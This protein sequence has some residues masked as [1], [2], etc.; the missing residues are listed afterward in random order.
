MLLFG[1]VMAAGF[2]YGIITSQRHALVGTSGLQAVLFVVLGLY[3]GHFWT[4][5]GQTLAMQTWR[6]RL[7]LPDGQPVTRSRATARYLLS[8]LWF[9]PAL[10]FLQLGGYK[11]SSAVTLALGIG[12]VV[13]AGLSRLRR[14]RQFL[15]DALCGTRLVD[16]ATSTTLPE[17]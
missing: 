17:R 11:S 2:V 3:F 6:I 10:L 15:H 5:R 16:V 14:D 9:A 1:V 4:T 7:A 13:Y 8:W 12:V